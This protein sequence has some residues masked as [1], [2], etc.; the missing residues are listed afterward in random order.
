[1]KQEA[2]GPAGF[3]AA[4]LTEGLSESSQ[5][6][7]SDPLGVNLFSKPTSPGEKSDEREYTDRYRQPHGKTV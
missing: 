2:R 5:R 3:F 7:I 4:C 1:L 6:L